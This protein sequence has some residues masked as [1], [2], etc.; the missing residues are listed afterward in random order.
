M[1]KLLAGVG[2][3]EEAKR[4]AQAIRDQQAAEHATIAEQKSISGT[5]WS[6]NQ[7]KLEEHKAWLTEIQG[8]LGEVRASFRQ[9]RDDLR[10]AFEN[11]DW[12]ACKALSESCEQLKYQMDELDGK[13]LSKK[14]EQAQ[15]E[16]ALLD[17]GMSTKQADIEL[18]KLG[19][20]LSDAEALF[21]GANAE[22][23]AH[24]EELK[25]MQEQYA[26]FQRQLAELE[27]EGCR[28]N[29]AANT[30]KFNKNLKIRPITTAR[31]CGNATRSRP[32]CDSSGS[33]V[34]KNVASS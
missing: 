33:K 10:K 8:S 26:L 15:F 30:E 32:I 21:G 34:V 16:R 25:E 11:K 13:H 22:F 7:R 1:K 17:T 3:K 9:T 6:E 12:S 23:S 20:L 27:E 18:N 28:V 29:L 24:A 14:D 2:G 19:D 5:E 31:L 4:K